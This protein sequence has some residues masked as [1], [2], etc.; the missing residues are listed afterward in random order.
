M[1]GKRDL[2]A[3]I[4]R[5]PLAMLV[6]GLAVVCALGSG[7]GRLYLE[8]GIDIFFA[9]DDPY[10]LAEQHL[11]D[12]Y[13]REDNIL[14]VVDT[15][16]SGVFSRD[17][18]VAL[19]RLAGRAWQMP[20]ARR[21]DSITNYLYPT[22]DGDDIRIDPLVEGAATLSATDIERIARIARGEKALVGRLLGPGADV[23]AVNVSLLLPSEDTPA[24]I[25]A[26]VG[27]ARELVR[28]TEAEHPD[29]RI[30]L[31][32]WAV[33][34]QT[35][36]EVT[37]QDSATLMPVLF[38]LVMV[39]LALLLR[40]VLAALLTALVIA[41]S[42]ATGLG[43][44][45]WAG[46]GL[47]SVSIS[48]PTI[49]LTLAI[50]DCIHVLTAFLRQL[51][52]E[53][54][55]RAAMA[56]ALR[57]TLY[58]V[59]LTSV[60]TALGF[61]SMNFSES[62]PFRDLGTIA[63]VGVMGALWVT[64]T[65]LPGLVLALPF[66]AAR[67]ARTGLPMDGF[68]RLVVRHQRTLFWASLGVILL[69]VAGLSRIELNDDPAGYF[70]AD[71][72]LTGTMDIVENR[73]SGTQVLHYSLPAGGAGAIAE[74]AFLAQ[75]EQFAA[76]LRAQPEVANVEVFTETLKRLNEVMHEGDPA[77]HRLPESRELAAQYTLLYEISVPYGQDVTHQVSA[78][79]S[80]LKLS[81]TLRNQQSRG[82][83]AF[84]HR[85]QAWMAANTPALSAQ[86]AGQS[87]SFANVGLRN[88]QSM[89][90]GSL[91]AV[92]LISGCLVLAFRSLR[93][94]LVSF[95]PNLFPAFV[96][97]GLWGW[98]VGEVNIAASVVF[99]LT[100]GIIVDDT[101]HFLVRYLQ[102]RRDMGLDA[103]AAVAHTFNTVGSALVST[104]LVLAIGF[105]ALVQSD[106]SVN[107]TSGLLV[108]VTI[109]VAIVLDLLFLPTVL[110][111][112]DRLLV[113]G[114]AGTPRDA[115]AAPNARGTRQ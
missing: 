80:A 26:A 51:R 60:T 28:E 73:L 34:E 89:L 44:A 53:P 81:A 108:A 106:F 39:L 98:L 56:H 99:S 40:S 25:A 79:K 10:L 66:R 45:G 94:G 7:A 77:W 33:T 91:V 8:S 113:G 42:V 3:L 95:I 63:A 55:R 29:L 105:L 14:F 112:A 83:V 30:H 6:L 67:G 115:A 71:V 24:A 4:M 27:F 100:L 86:G 54:D 69:A 68:A 74:P 9:D 101:T 15:G 18:L 78:D 92:L 75:V 93:F 31:A 88:I 2:T 107:A 43:Y 85:A 109:T 16:D 102:G 65:I 87:I 38:A 97:L 50:A 32:G 72:P 12:T 111:R 76:W 82:I 47:N 104:S 35:L 37:A 84:D 57:E 41:L 19:E 11:K 59:T 62:P 48:A 58:P 23:V 49:I 90:A 13:G 114:S 20:S 5:H 22:V 1:A 21:V 61:L 46:T 17:T 103:A 96:T 36:A 70:D 110:M 64:V 52:T